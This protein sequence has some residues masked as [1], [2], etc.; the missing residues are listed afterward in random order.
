MTET[1][2][3]TVRAYAAV[4]CDPRFVLGKTNELLLRH[5]VDESHVTALLCLLDPRT[6]RLSLASTGHPAP[7]RLACTSCESLDVPFGPPLGAFVC[8]YEWAHA[9]LERG[10]CLVLFTDGVSEARRDGEELGDDGVVEIVERL[11]GL[12]AAG[13][14]QSV[15]DA[16]LAFSG[17]LRDDLHVV[18]V[19]LA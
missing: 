18:A 6:G 14:A 7:V 8:G 16:A 2:R 17:A 3:S 12:P 9:G 4:D 11:R 10:D 1:V 5:Y 13:V 19:R 15:A